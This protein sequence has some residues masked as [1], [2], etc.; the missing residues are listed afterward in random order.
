MKVCWSRRAL[1]DLERIADRIAADKP[2]AATKFAAGVRA[3]VDSLSRFP[4]L[5]RTGAYQDT[6]ELVVHKN[7]LVTYRVRGSEVQVLQVWHV[8]RGTPRA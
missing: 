3:K 4:L 8:A 2:L 6:R 5:G 7:Y 1:A